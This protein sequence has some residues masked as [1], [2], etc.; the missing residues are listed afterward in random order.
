[1]FSVERLDWAVGI[2]IIIIL[3]LV[4]R[5]IVHLRGLY[6]FNNYEEEHLAKLDLG[7]GAKAKEDVKET[8]PINGIRTT[9][10]LYNVLENFPHP[11]LPIINKLYQRC[12]L[13]FT[14]ACD[15][16][17]FFLKLSQT[18]EGNIQ[19]MHMFRRHV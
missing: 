11:P 12:A 15:Y 16:R 8:I 17:T 5:Q 13:D 2:L 9:T 7:K 6:I 4:L 14:R 10:I 18:V 3:Q 19:L 1:M